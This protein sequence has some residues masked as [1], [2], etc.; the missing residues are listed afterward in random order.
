MKLLT[1]LVAS[2][3]INFQQ[4]AVLSPVTEQYVDTEKFEKIA[5]DLLKLRFADADFIQT[6]VTENKKGRGYDVYLAFSAEST[7]VNTCQVHMNQHDNRRIHVE[8]ISCVNYQKKIGFR[9]DI[10]TTIYD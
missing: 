10:G 4:P 1:V 2:S 5:T 8:S 9:E 6:T 3:I 7:P